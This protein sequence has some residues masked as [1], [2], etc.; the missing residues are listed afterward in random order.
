[1]RSKTSFIFLWILA[2]A[3]IGD[4]LLW[5]MAKRPS[6]VISLAEETAPS[7]LP[8]VSLQDCYQL[9]L[10]QSETLAL[11]GISVEKSW[12]DFLKASSQ[13]L[14]DVTYNATNFFQDPQHT[15]SADGSGVSSSFTREE[16]RERTITISQPLFQGFKALGAVVGAGSL[17]KERIYDL[18]RARQTLF[19]ET[20]LSFYTV[21][22]YQHELEIQ[23]EILKLLKDRVAELRERTSIGKSRSSELATALSQSQSLEAGLEETRGLHRSEIR[24]LEFLTGS[25]MEDRELVDTTPLSHTPELVA[26]FVHEAALRK[27]VQAADQAVKTAFQA[28]IVAQSKLWPTVT[29]DATH[30]EKREAFQAGIDWD[31]LFTAKV[32]IFQGGEAV[33]DLKAAYSDWKKAKVMYRQTERQAELQIKQAYESWLSTQQ[34][35]RAWEAAVWSSEVNYQLQ[36]NDYRKNLVNNLDVL[37]ALQAFN[38]ARKQKN[39]TLYQLKSEYWRLEIARGRCCESA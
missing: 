26:N 36:K 1:M 17:R 37:S 35:F 30:Y 39:R 4:P 10:R 8:P 25:P 22:R 16:R 2:L 31:V 18:D 34:Q 12:S 33:G 5:A 28:I 3:F 19:L 23:N 14:G 7:P 32:P 29:L 27:D 21:L 38:E 6:R 24:M 15:V 20:A 13:A 11:K 9:A